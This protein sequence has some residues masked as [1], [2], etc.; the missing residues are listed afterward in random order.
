MKRA[1]FRIGA[2]LPLLAK[3]RTEGSQIDPRIR[4]I[5]GNNSVMVARRSCFLGLV[6][7]NR[8]ILSHFG[9]YRRMPAAETIDALSY[10][11]LWRN[12]SSQQSFLRDEMEIH[13]W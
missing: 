5:L 1:A 8:L 13:Y 7:H 12:S 6:F 2:Y 9:Y 10:S 3:I 4:P 11:P